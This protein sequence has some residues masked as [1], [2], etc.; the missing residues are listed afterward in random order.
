MSRNNGGISCRSCNRNIGKFNRRGTELNYDVGSF[1]CTNH[2]RIIAVITQTITVSVGLCGIC[3]E[4]TVVGAVV[5]AVK[6]SIGVSTDAYALLTG[7]HLRTD[8]AVVTCSAVDLHRIRAVAGLRI[9][10]AG[11]VT[12]IAGGTN[13]SDADRTHSRLT[14]VGL[15]TRVAVVTYGAVSRVR[16]CRTDTGIITNLSGVALVSRCARSQ[17]NWRY[18]CRPWSPPHCRDRFDLRQS[19]K[20]PQQ[21]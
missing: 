15:R 20:D 5:N 8:V 19:P 17:S 6:T 2:G 11:V 13:S 10:G 18:R 21:Y 9:T 3:D 7:I 4:L 1:K 14:S 12:L 16:I